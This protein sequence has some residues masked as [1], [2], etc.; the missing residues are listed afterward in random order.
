MSFKEVTTLRKSGQLEEATTMARAD[1]E[2]SRDKWSCNALFWCLNDKAQNANIEELQEIVEEMRALMETIGDD[3][4]PTKSLRKLESRLIPHAAEIR[5]AGEDAKNPQL[6]RNAF[7]TVVAIFNNNELDL[8]FHKDFGWI[9]YRALHA[10]NSENVEYRKELLNIYLQLE[11]ERPSMLH[12]LILT[13]AV[14]VEK[15]WPQQFMFTEFVARWDLENLTEDDWAR[16]VT[17][18]GKTMLSRVEKMIYLYTKEMQAVES[19]LPSDDFSTVLDSA[20][21]KWATDDNLLRCK[22]MLC[23]KIADVEKAISCYKE[24]ITLSNGQKFFLWSELANLVEDVD[25]Q[26]GLLSKALLLPNPEEFCGKIRLQLAKLLSRKQMFDYAKHELDKVQLIYVGQGWR[27]PQEHYYL[28]NEIP[29]NITA[30][31]CSTQYTNWA[32]TADQYM[33]ASLPSITMIKIAERIDMI[34]RQGQRPKRVEKWTLIDQ[35]GETIVVKPKKFNLQRVDIGCCFEVKKASNQPVLIHPISPE[36]VSWRREVV[37][38]ISIRTNREGKRFGF[39]DNC[40]IHNKYIGN[41]VDGAEVSGVAILRED[42]WTIVS[43]KNV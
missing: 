21:S 5:Q 39:V 11:I 31:D 40:Y 4:V 30:E 36:N 16:F 42:R 38:T 9:I 1:I 27:L 12:S 13:E 2:R 29:A 6:V 14:R 18:D 43:I 7:E 22:A 25:L 28:L 26:I 35:S 20:I 10:D 37:G 33:Y 3:D 8:S 17:D 32:Q 34:E 41:I 19:L 23:V 15:E 24:A